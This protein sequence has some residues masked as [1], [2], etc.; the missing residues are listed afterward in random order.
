MKDVDLRP[1]IISVLLTPFA[2]YASYV[3]M[4]SGQ[5]SVLPEALFPYTALSIPLTG[6]LF[7]PFLLLA[8]VQFPL[9]GVILAFAGKSK[10]FGAAAIGL[11]A[12]HFLTL[13][14]CLIAGDR[15]FS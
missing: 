15:T 6:K 11:L 10:K 3:S 5:D 14:L 13:V 8:V 4:W 1:I 9:Y 7:L 12:L 2:L